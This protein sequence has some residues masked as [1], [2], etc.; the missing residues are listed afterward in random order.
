MNKFIEVINMYRGMK[1]E[2]YILVICMLINGIGNFVYPLLT[3]IL[4]DRVSLSSKKIGMIIMCFMIVQGVFMALSGI[5]IDRFGRKIMLQVFY[6][7]GIISYL[8]CTV[9]K[10]GMFIFFLFLASGAFLSSTPI[11]NTLIGDYT[12]NSDRKEAFSLLYLANNIGYAIAPLLSG[13]L[14]ANHI[15][16]LF[17][18]NSLFTFI[19]IVI[20][21][22]F[23]REKHSNRKFHKVNNIN[24]TET[25]TA[26]KTDK[27]TVIIRD[28]PTCNLLVF[29][30]NT[31]ILIIGAFIVFFFQFGYSQWGFLLPMQLLSYF[32]K[33]GAEKY[34]ILGAVNGI[35]VI[36]ITPVLTIIFKKI[37]TSYNLA[38]GG[39][40]YATAFFMFSIA[41]DYSLFVIGIIIMTMGEIYVSINY[42]VLIANNSD[43]RYRGR[44]N[45]I[46]STI[47]GGGL[48]LGPVVIGYLEDFNYFLR[49]VIV[50]VVLILASL[51]LLAIEFINSKKVVNK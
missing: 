12:D 26:I 37:R 11:Y 47:T 36:L 13:I 17:Y 41:K 31:P 7:L 1:K 5:L 19:S 25:E 8:L 39:I 4:T 38:L 9:C 48:A 10:D 14:Y 15:K 45:S 32:G 43:N 18:L 50:S 3:I 34:G 21:S 16:L 44:I 23:I 40:L 22:I 20:F 46:L 29:F 51:T 27:D 49:W 6:S 33:Q 24:K 35:A 30:K 2:V 42:Q 28:E